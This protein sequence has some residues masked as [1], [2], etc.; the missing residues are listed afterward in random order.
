[1]KKSLITLSFAFILLFISCKPEPITPV[2]IDLS[3][4]VFIVNEGNF[5]SNNGEISFYNFVT[6]KITNRLFASQNNDAVLGDVIQSLCIIDSFGL[7]AVNNSKKI[8]IVNI[9]TLKHS[10][11]IAG[12]SYPRYIIPVRPEICY[13]SNGKNPGQV[14]VLNTRSKTFIDT[15]PVGN[16]PENMLLTDNKVFVANGA[17]GHDSTVTIIDAVTDTVVFTLT[18]G[19]GACDLVCDQSKRIWVLCQGKTLHDNPVETPS[20]LVCIN[21]LNF[22]IECEVPI[23]TPNDFFYPSRLSC[24]PQ[25]NILYYIEKEGVY[26]LNAFNSNEHQ[27]LIPGSFYGLEVNPETGD[28]YVLSDNAFSKPGTLSIYNPSGDLI[29]QNIQTGIGPNSAVFKP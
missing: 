22:Q 26:K 18:V 9:N 21:P 24:N 20:K 29:I 14:L 28:I 3:N 12:V 23:G 8:E 1:M 11:T 25:K 13:L 15:I 7:I 5:M 4:G 2:D 10:H 19:D 27:L 16:E 6:G 17:W